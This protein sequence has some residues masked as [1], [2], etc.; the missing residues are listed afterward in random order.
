[1]VF[2]KIQEIIAGRIRERHRRNQINDKH[3]RRP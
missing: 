3:P 1:M 2:E